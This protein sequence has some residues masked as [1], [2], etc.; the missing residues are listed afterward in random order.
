MMAAPNGGDEIGAYIDEVAE[1]SD[2]TMQVDLLTRDATEQQ[3]GLTGAQVNAAVHD[4]TVPLALVT[5]RD[6]DSLGVATLDALQA[7]L[8]VDSL[9]LEAALL[10]DAEVTGP[11][12][13]GIGTLGVEPVGILPGPLVRPFGIT[14]PL[15]APSDYVGATI[16]APPG[17][18]AARTLSLLG[19]NAV[20]SPFNGASVEEDDGALMQLASV[21]GNAY[22]AAGRSVTADVALWPRLL[23]VV[24][25]PEA[26]AALTDQQQAALR[27]SVAASIP[28]IVSA[29]EAMEAE[30]DQ[31]GCT[32]GLTLPTAGAGDLAAMRAA[33]QPLVDQIGATDI[34]A[35][36]FARA[37]ELR[38]SL[39][40]PRAPICPTAPA[41]WPTEVS[42]RLDG[43]YAGDTTAQDDLDQGVPANE[44][45]PENW[46]HW[47]LVVKDGRYARTQEN[48]AACTWE[49]GDWRMDDTLVRWTIEAG[50]G[51]APNNAL[52]KSGEDFIFDW[53]DFDGTLKLT[54][55][56]ADGPDD[57]AYN[58][59]SDIPDVSAFPTRCAPPAEA[60][61]GD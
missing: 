4:G 47:V 26:F 56:V 9:D 24:A 34:G 6:L 28:G 27:E 2:D 33:V 8:V 53:T 51:I 52:A 43:T 50:G 32:G 61:T 17:D 49:Y 29:N 3:V 5:A 21:T 41:D 60:L 44:I 22:H 19:A 10:Q 58:R 46:G 18:I 14:R 57:V 40:A 15:L 38:T 48:D 23:V 13:E 25:N 35:A 12:L 54:L 11:M 7:P 20:E 16:A 30:A 42:S 45:V 37:E 39:P 31:I 55:A 36:L 1:Q 59:I